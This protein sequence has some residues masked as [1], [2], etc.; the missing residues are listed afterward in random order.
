[1]MVFKFAIS[2]SRVA[3]PSWNISSKSCWLCWRARSSFCKL[4]DRAGDAGGGP[5]AK[6]NCQQNPSRGRKHG[7]GADVLLQF[8]VGPAGVADHQNAQQFIVQAEKWNRVDSFFV[9]RI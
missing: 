6:K 7:G 2:A 1:M 5:S 3:E 8:N 9:A 4:L